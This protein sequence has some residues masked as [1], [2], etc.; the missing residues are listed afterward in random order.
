VD[1]TTSSRPGT[2]AEPEEAVASGQ[3][4]S[5]VS[6]VEFAMLYQAEKPLLVRYLMQSGATFHDAEAAA[7]VALADL[8]KQWKTVRSPRSWLRIV[9]PRKL[10]QGKAGVA[11]IALEG[12]D[13]PGTLP[14]PAD[15]ES[16]QRDTVV[17]A[18]LKLPPLQGKVFALYFDQFGSRE[19]AEILHISKASVRQHLARARARLRELP[20]FAKYSPA[21]RDRAQGGDQKG[22]LNE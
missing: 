16:L 12:Q 8:Y 18:I 4:L 15:I 5:D 2:P 1:D 11:E 19:I 20:E 3:D 6:D 14:D 13:P 21:P 9:A 22:G 7:Q 17:S 10:S